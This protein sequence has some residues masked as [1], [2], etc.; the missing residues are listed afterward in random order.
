MEKCVCVHSL[1]KGLIWCVCV[2]FRT[3]SPGMEVHTPVLFLDLNGKW[4]A[5]S[6]YVYVC[7]CVC[8][9]VCASVRACLCVCVLSV[10][11]CV[12]NVDC[13]CLGIIESVHDCLALLT[14]VDF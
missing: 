7:V 14:T 11:I 5:F 9:C 12:S 1:L 3:P 2:C 13:C 4:L 6:V 10:L 8:V